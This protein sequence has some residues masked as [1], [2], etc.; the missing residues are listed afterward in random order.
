MQ[1]GVFVENISEVTINSFETALQLLK[2]GDN[3]KITAETKLNEKSSRSHSIFR[4]SLET[5]YNTSENKLKTF[6]SQMN[7]IDLAGSEN[8]VKAKTDGLRQKEGSNINKSLLALSNCIQK[9][10]HNSKNF[11]SYRDSKLTRLLQ[12]ALTGNSKTS[13]ICTISES[14]QC[15]SETVN[16]LHFGI[17]A[18]NIKTTIKIN[19][20][21]DEKNKIINENINLKNKIKQLEE[22]I[23]EKRETENNTNYNN[24]SINN[25]L[26]ENLNNKT[27][28]EM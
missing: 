9:L 28:N 8:V 22:M 14:Q 17:K 25:Q 11:V 23:I 4:I 13:I 2:Q 18:K 24:K 12:T 20:L 16:T 6:I 7:I 10:S 1:K 5:Q 3:L 27:Q 21:L 26:D 15:Y 19:E